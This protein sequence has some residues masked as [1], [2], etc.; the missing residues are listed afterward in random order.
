MDN[1]RTLMY[2][3]CKVRAVLIAERSLKSEIDLL[4]GPSFFNKMYRKMCRCVFSSL[5]KRP[6]QKDAEN[7][8]C[9]V[10]QHQ[11]LIFVILSLLINYT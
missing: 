10:L 11:H 3:N 5:R 7:P 2:N 1:A 6:F 8:L 4:F 9:A